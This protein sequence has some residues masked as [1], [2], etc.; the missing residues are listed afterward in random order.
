[1]RI[2]IG[3]RGADVDVDF[4]AHW[5]ITLDPGAWVT[6]YRGEPVSVTTVYGRRVGDFFFVAYPKGVS[7]KAGGLWSIQE[8]ILVDLLSDD[9]RQ[10]WRELPEVVRS[11][12]ED[13]YLLSRHELPEQLGAS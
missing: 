2:A 6:D 7:R 9:S 8:R 5:R 4:E 1:M 10:A 12:L 11:A 3:E 13:A